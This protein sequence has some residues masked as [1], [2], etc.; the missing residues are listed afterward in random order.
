MLKK[1]IKDSIR[2][3]AGIKEI[4]IPKTKKNPGINVEGEAKV[5]YENE[6]YI[7]PFKI[8][9]TLCSKC[10]KINSEYYEAILQLRNP[11][12]EAIKFIE[13]DV[14]KNKEK[15]VFITKKEDVKNGIDFY[16]TSQR[17]TQSLGKKLN[18]TFNGEL[19]LSRKLFTTDKQRSKHVYRVN[20]LFRLKTRA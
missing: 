18:K 15:G 7:I 19:K 4:N 16:V 1:I 11:S 12:K 20:V 10:S 5:E 6:I 17:Y 14:K 8:R 9:Y 2:E 13:N 3:K